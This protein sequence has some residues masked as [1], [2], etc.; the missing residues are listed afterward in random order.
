L[1]GGSLTSSE[2]SFWMRLVMLI[3]A[4]VGVYIRVFNSR[5]CIS[6]YIYITY[7]VYQ[8]S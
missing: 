8:F 7:F 3:F 6:I 1:E 5:F 2:S 4:S